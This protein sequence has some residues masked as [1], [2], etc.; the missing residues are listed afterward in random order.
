[1]E[2]FPW[3][4]LFDPSSNPAS[5]ENSDEEGENDAGNGDCI[6][7]SIR[8][9][10]ERAMQHMFQMSLQKLHTGN[11]PSKRR[12]VNKASEASEASEA[13]NEFVPSTQDVMEEDRR[14]HEDIARMHRQTVQENDLQNDSQTESDSESDSES[15]SESDGTESDDTE[16]DDTESDDTENDGTESDDSRRSTHNSSHA[17]VREKKGADPCFLCAYC[18]T[19]E[20]KCITCFIC[21]NIANMDI[22]YMAQ[23]I[24][25]F[26]F[27]KRPELQRE[28]KKYGL[29]V[30]TIR[31]HIRLHMLAPTVRIADMMRHLL[32]LCDTLR[33]NLYRE[34][35]DT[36]DVCADRGNIDTYLKVI[37][38]VLNM[39]KMA[40]PSK[41]LFAQ[42]QQA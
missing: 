17:S 41:M 42:Q 15:G 14:E 29:E 2:E 13:D 34:D 11:F 38:Q 7:K 28:S 26:M 22:G 25:E 40:E 33:N 18:T 5:Y 23:Q 16:S 36:G 1:M 31:K 32:A 21:D 35:P 24:R 4:I 10:K 27:E 3:C 9:T 12:K 37:T 20:V 6:Q 19:D 8:Q 39:Y 30:A